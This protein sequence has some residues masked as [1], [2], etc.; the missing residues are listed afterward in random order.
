MSH[1]S[2]DVITRSLRTQPQ[3]FSSSF[4]ILASG[5]KRPPLAIRQ[6]TYGPIFPRAPLKSTLYRG[7]YHSISIRVPPSSKTFFHTS[8]CH[9]TPQFLLLLFAPFSRILVAIGSR[10]TRSWWKRLTPE[11]KQAIKA[12]IARQR[13]YIYGFL[14][15]LT[16][17]GAGFYLA[18]LEETPLTGRRRFVMFSRE[19]VLS[20]VE[21]EKKNL[22]ELICEN[23]QK[24]LDH[25]HPAY[26]HVHT[27]VSNILTGNNVPEFEGFH[28]ALYVID[29][30]DVVNAMCLPTGDIF[31]Y[32]G[33]VDQCKNDEELAFIL[34][35]EIAHAVL[36]H[37]VE[38][39]SRNGVVNFVQLFLIAVIWA[40]I[41][42]DLVSY[43]MH[44]FSRSTVQVM[45]E[46]PHSRKLET[47]ADK[48]YR[49][50]VVL[51]CMYDDSS[52]SSRATT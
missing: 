9:H 29:K 13:K 35:H 47:E 49:Q 24:I 28:W 5:S 21:S 19:E 7:R 32:T 45:L 15:L 39:L 38:A 43:F 34:S 3:R 50:C 27:V 8:S 2:V 14:G 33:L 20:M 46:Y 30:P 40:V 41:P 10:L 11:R 25:N 23:D 16:L 51:A 52:V 36:G 18:H 31:V 6:C 48:V 42:S 4:S 37:G 12:A 26:K 22:L 1:V 17:C 44:G